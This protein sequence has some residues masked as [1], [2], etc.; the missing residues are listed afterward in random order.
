LV[1]TIVV[2]L[3]FSWLGVEIKK[4]SEQTEAMEAI[5]KLQG[6]LEY[7]FEHN[8]RGTPPANVQRPGS[9][10]LRGLLGDDFFA[11]VFHVSLTGKQKDT[12]AVLAHLNGQSQV[13]WLVLIDLNV[14]DA[15]LAKLKGWTNL[16]VLVLN[17]SQIT[18]A[19]LEH[20]RTLSQLQELSLERT[21][22]TDAGMEHLNGLAKLQSLD[23][24]ETKV[25]D[26]GLAN[27]E[28]LR[29]L[30]E[31]YLGSERITDAGLTH[32]ESLH[33][34]EELGL[35]GDQITDA[36]LV[37]LQSLRKLK[38]LKLSCSISDVGM[39]HLLP[40]TNLTKLV[41]LGSPNDPVKEKVLS[42]LRNPTML[43][44]VNTPLRDVCEYSQD[45]HRIKF[46]IDEPALKDAKTGRFRS[47]TCNIK[48]I[49][50]RAALDALLDP[51]GLAWYVGPGD[52]VITTKAAYAI[53]H[54]NLFRLQQA[55]PNLKQVEVDW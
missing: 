6:L 10:W 55:L 21:E 48:G 43:E 24:V 40:L 54:A 15:W 27:L 19:G 13:Q 53:R 26:A 5:R 8:Q 28:S 4:A 29:Q 45:L 42:T 47:V 33:E 1:L 7:D 22:V 9:A 44:F 11:D 30:K 37:H 35:F 3:P 41:S 2:A 16:H 18:D 32:L 46:E 50:L 25:T 49:R 14:T 20:L 31:L 12:D 36:G 38:N 17:G 23:L 51:L 34:L 39:K 52:V